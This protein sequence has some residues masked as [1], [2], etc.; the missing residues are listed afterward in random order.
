VST[1]IR[2]S[3]VAWLQLATLRIYHKAT[4]KEIKEDIRRFRHAPEYFLPFVEWV[5]GIRGFSYDYL[6]DIPGFQERG[7][8]LQREFAEE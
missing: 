3:T 5:N 8:F 6:P 1:R 2:W 4:Q 7:L